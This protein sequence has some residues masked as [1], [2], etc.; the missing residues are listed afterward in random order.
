MLGLC[1]IGI[2]S[3]LLFYNYITHMTSTI[4]W[5]NTKSVP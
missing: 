2:I 1:I 5:T 3:T 4:Y